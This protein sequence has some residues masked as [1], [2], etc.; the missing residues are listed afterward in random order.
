MMAPHVNPR[1]TEYGIVLRGSGTI[2]IGYPNGSSAVNAKVQEGDVFMVP[3][4]FPFCQISSRSGALEFFGFTTSSRRNRPQFLV[5]RN[6]VLQTLLG[7]ELA[8][9]FGGDNETT[10]RA[11]L[12]AQRE[13]VIL[14]SASAAPPDDIANGQPQEEERI[15]KATEDL[16]Q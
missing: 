13:A 3:R 7:P 12:D 16:R 15:E 6:S 14:P 4:Y 8:A 11:F 1:A 5:G 9:A 10:I 2:Q